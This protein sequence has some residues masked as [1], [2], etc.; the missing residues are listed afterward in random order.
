LVNVVKFAHGSF[1][2]TK[3]NNNMA[4]QTTWAIDPVHSHLQFKVKHLMIS[5]VNCAF[6]TFRGEVKTEADDFNHAAVSVEIDANSI[7]TNHAERDMHLKSSLFLDSEKFPKVNFTGI[8][9]KKGNEYELMGGLTLCGVTKQL[10][11]AVEFT[12]T[13]QGLHKETRAGF[14]VSGKINRKDFG[15]DFNLLTDTGSIVVGEELKL[16]FNIEVI[17]QAA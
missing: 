16:Q 12:G 5:T 3:R 15:L 10:T 17:K 13:C 4:T 2:Q 1:V 8:L 11:L 7:S 6:K 9:Q 14:D